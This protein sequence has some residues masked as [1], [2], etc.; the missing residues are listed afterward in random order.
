[1]YERKIKRYS[2]YFLGWCQAFGEHEIFF[3]E[4]DDVNWLFGEAKIGINFSPRVRRLFLKEMLKQNKENLSL[5]ISNNHIQLGDLKYHF[6]SEKDNYGLTKILDL[7]RNNEEI[8]L[9]LTSHF[10]YPP[11]TRIVTLSRKKPFIILYKEIES[12]TVKVF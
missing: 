1:M 12:L 11:G 4:E 7:L 3:R 8:H 5:I 9:F 10:C 2:A 6:V